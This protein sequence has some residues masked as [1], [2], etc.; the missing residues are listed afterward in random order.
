M[1]SSESSGPL[2]GMWEPDQLGAVWAGALVAAVIIHSV[3]FGFMTAQ[4]QKPKPVPIVMAIALPPP[5]PPPEPEPPTKKKASP[6][7]EQAL[8]PAPPAPADTPPPP[9]DAP[10]PKVADE[11][12]NLA[13]PTGQGVTVP[14]GSA[15]GQDGA[16]PVSSTASSA[17]VPP[18]NRGQAGP[19]V[20]QWDAS[21]YKSGA[22]DLMNRN[23]Q[24]PRKAQVM[25]L[26]GK[27]IVSVK[28]NHDG[29]LAAPPKILGKGT[30][31]DV[32]DAE[33]IAMAERTKFPS[34]PTHIPAPVAMR[35]PIEF[36]LENR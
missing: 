23:K 1:S 33:C 18:T 14:V 28:L 27:C 8:P 31:H 35:F 34:I 10:P 25:G 22:W 4:P 24:Y 20:D 11:V 15:D 2:Q 17:E 21:G 3:A 26:E 19:P 13:P 29:T 7:P 36:V 16:P 32:L 12:V 6:P 5:P 9:A 30:G